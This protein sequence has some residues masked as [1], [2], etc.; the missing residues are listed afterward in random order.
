MSVENDRIYMMEENHEMEQ[1]EPT[2]SQVESFVI[3]NIVPAANGRECVDGRYDKHG[4]ES[5]YIARAGGDFGYV[6]GL[7]Y[8][9]NEG[10]I[11]SSVKECVDAVYQAVTENGDKFFM[12]TDQHASH[13]GLF[14]G[15][16]HIMKASLPEHSEKYGIK[17]EDIIEAHSYARNSSV[18]PHTQ[19]PELVGNH[20]ERG[21]L[22]VNSKTNTLDHHDEN[23]MYFV[24]DAIRDKNFID[25]L[26]NRMQ[27]KGLTKE[28]FTAA[29]D[30]QTQA[31]LSLLAPEK[32]IIN[33]SFG[34]GKP[35]LELAG[36]VEA[37]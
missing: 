22:I 32:P 13:E 10:T 23:D 9:K 2:L 4:V 21:V 1:S 31:T 37:V 6:M 15:C 11:E 30:K 12:H 5:G 3:K 36:F 35:N 27:I 25:Y 16:G 7:L 26:V 34:G 8:L 18:H 33:V 17:P 20:Q 14:T 19:E 24:Y 29:L 28:N